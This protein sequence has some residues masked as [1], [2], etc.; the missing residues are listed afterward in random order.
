MID[1]IVIDWGK[2]EEFIFNKNLIKI[3]CNYKKDNPNLTT[4]KIGELMGFNY[5]TIRDWLKT[6]NKL[7]WCEYD[8]KEEKIKKYK[9]VICVE[10]G[11]IYDKISIAEKLTNSRN[12]GA[13]CRGERN[14]A[15]KLPDGTKLH[16]EYVEE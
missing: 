3:A 16:W 13:C 10:T 8:S 12:V 14:Y 11:I 2:C 1:I 7:G 4:T 5:N 9:K 15:G 6:G